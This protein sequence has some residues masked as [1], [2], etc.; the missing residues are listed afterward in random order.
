MLVEAY[1]RAQ[2]LLNLLRQRGWAGWTRLER[3]PR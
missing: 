2:R 3:L 1:P